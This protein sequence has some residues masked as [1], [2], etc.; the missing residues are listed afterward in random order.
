MSRALEGRRVGSGRAESGSTAITGRH[1][2]CHQR[3]RRCL[4]F[5]IISDVSTHGCRFGVRGGLDDL[6]R[7]S[8]SLSLSLSHSKEKEERRKETKREKDRDRKQISIWQLNLAGLLPC[9][10]A[11][12]VAV[13]TGYL[14]GHS[15]PFLPF[16]CR[17]SLSLS[18]SSSSSSNQSSSKGVGSDGFMSSC[19]TRS[20]AFVRRSFFFGFV[21]FLFHFLIDWL[22]SVSSSARFYPGWPFFCFVRKTLQTQVKLGESRFHCIF[23]SFRIKYMGEIR[24]HVF[25]K[26][27][28]NDLDEIEVET[29]QK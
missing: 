13:L 23:F 2:G 29:S 1:C 12:V 28:P 15:R 19:G 3:S 11:D 27:W 9:Y 10:L 14:S 17:F 7:L 24:E 20:G 6:L 18:L 4:W 8:P 22:S 26:S 21:L 16:S 5:R 25:M